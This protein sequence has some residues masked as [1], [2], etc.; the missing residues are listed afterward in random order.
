MMKYQLTKD[1]PMLCVVFT[2]LQ[3]LVIL[4]LSLIYL[5]IHR[6]RTMSLPSL[7]AS[8]PQRQQ[9]QQATINYYRTLP[10]SAF[11]NRATPLSVSA[12]TT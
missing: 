9:Q 11:C 4:L 6:I 1:V 3:L 12:S 5:E 8:P 10:H 2:L 7:V